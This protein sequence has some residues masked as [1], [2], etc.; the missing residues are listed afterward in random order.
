MKKALAWYWL[1]LVALDVFKQELPNM[2][3]LAGLICCWTKFSSHQTCPEEDRCIS[4]VSI[5]RNWLKRSTSRHS[6]SCSRELE[7]LELKTFPSGIAG[8]KSSLFCLSWTTCHEYWDSVCANSYNST[9]F[10]SFFWA[11]YRLEHVRLKGL[12][13]LCLISRRS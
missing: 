2:Q 13:S 1:L 6:P 7:K 10:I 12:I 4:H 11:N 3:A 9:P 5:S 8:K